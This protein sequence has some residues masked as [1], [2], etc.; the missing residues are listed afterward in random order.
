M[1][2]FGKK[3]AF[4]EWWK[5][6]VFDATKASAKGKPSK[7]QPTDQEREKAKVKERTAVKE[8]DPKETK[9]DKEK[10]WNLSM[11]SSKFLSFC[12]FINI[13][14]SRKKSR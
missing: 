1:F 5:C 13:I 8:K 9:T 3:A 7:A 10:P 12:L 14:F 11:V 2:F 6:F 4:G